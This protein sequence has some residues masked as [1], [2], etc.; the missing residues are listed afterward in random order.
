[1]VAAI[2]QEL[3]FGWFE[4]IYRK[5]PEA[6]DN[7]VATEEMRAAAVE[8]MPSAEFERPPTLESVVVGIDGILLDRPDCLVV[9]RTLDLSTF[10]GAGS[11]STAVSVLWPERD[12]WRL[13]NTWSSQNDLWLPDCDLRNRS[14]EP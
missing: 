5:D 2:L 12:G 6:L 10:R 14:T 4:A 1:E 13:V 9:A 11:T 8:A 3:Y 7:V